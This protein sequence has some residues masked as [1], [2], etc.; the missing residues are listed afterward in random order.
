MII[1]RGVCQVI[2]LHLRLP[3]NNIAFE[4]GRNAIMA[5]SSLKIC[6]ETIQ[7]EGDFFGD[8]C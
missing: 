8:G 5:I 1:D 2:R 4:T 3:A 7:V 6:L